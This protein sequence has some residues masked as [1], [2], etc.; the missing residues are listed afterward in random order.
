MSAETRPLAFVWRA[1]LGAITFGMV[2]AYLFARPPLMGT[3]PPIEH[4]GWFL[5]SIQGV[6]AT[7]VSFLVVGAV[8]GLSRA[9][10]LRSAAT[11]VVAGASVAIIAVYAWIG[12]GNLFP[13]VIVVGAACIGTATF[14]GTWVA[15]EARRR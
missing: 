14:A 6:I 7:G 15:I 2:Q 10:T 9:T 8:S 1:L 11:P 5:N 13:I 12:G 3:L 4:P